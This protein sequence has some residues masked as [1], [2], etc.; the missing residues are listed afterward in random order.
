VL[1]TVAHAKS[2]ITDDEEVKTK[3]NRMRKS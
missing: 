3:Y 1:V 2:K